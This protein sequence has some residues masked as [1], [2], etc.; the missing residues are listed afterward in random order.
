MIGP[1]IL[2]LAQ[3][4]VFSTLIIFPLMLLVRAG[5]RDNAPSHYQLS[6][7][8]DSVV[9]GLAM[10]VFTIMAGAVVLVGFHWDNWYAILGPVEVF[11]FLIFMPLYKKME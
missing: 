2:A 4:F 10:F 3:S 8:P 11:L 9:R 5:W 6:N 7:L 1:Q